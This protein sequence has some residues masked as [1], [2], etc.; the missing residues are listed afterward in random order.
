MTSR[1]FCFWLQ[2]LFEVG[3]PVSLDAEQTEM[4]KKHLG[5]VFQ[6]EIAPSVNRKTE[7]VLPS[8]TGLS[9]TGVCGDRGVLIC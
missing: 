5:L 3:K 2:G 1:D 9:T 8:L 4:L 7:P 6:H